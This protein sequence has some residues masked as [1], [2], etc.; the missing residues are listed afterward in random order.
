[1]NR[2]RRLEH[3][4]ETG[5]YH[6]MTRGV[7]KQIIFEDDADRKRYLNY[8]YKYVSEGIGV[9]LYAWCLMNNHVHLLV[10]ADVSALSAFMH[11]V[12]LAYAQSFNK[13]CERVGPLFQGRFRSEPIDSDEHLLTVLRYIHQNP[14]KAGLTRDCSYRWSSYTAYIAQEA[15]LGRPQSWIMELFGDVET[16]IKFHQHI[17]TNK[18]LP[19]KSYG[20][21]CEVD[22]HLS[23]SANELIAPVKVTEMRGLERHARNELLLTLAQYGFSARQIERL[24]GLSK[25]QVAKVVNSHT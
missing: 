5:I 12:N 8:L 11:R 23:R 22:D 7:G 21:K 10:Q 13:R 1:M 14:L 25:S 20:S 24:T 16:F 19:R 18:L 3:M 15:P 17:D 4:A 9:E 6:V 2:Y